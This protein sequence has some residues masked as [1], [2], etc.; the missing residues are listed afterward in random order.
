MTFEKKA[1]RVVLITGLSTALTI[2]FS[3]ISVPILLRY[4]GEGKYSEWIILISA[5]T[6]VTSVESRF[7]NYVG[8]KINYLYHKDKNKTIRYLSSAIVGI[9]LII[10]LQL[11]VVILSFKI[12]YLGNI[13]GINHKFNGLNNQSIGLLILLISW[14]ITGSYIVILHRLL[15]PTGLMVEGAWWAIFL[16]FF[17]FLVIIV[18]AFMDLSIPLAATFYAIVQAIVYILTAIYIRYKI[19]KLFPDI[20]Y[21]DVKTGVNI[22]I[23]SVPYIISNIMQQF[24]NSGMILLLTVISGLS[25]VPQ[26]STVKLLSSIWGNVSNILVQPILPE[27]IRLHAN[28]EFR[29]ISLLN[30]TYQATACNIINWGIILSY[31]IMGYAYRI[32]TSNLLILNIQLLCCFLLSAVL[33]NSGSLMNCY[34]IGINNKKFNLI[35]S[36]TRSIISISLAIILFKFFRIT[37]IGLAITIS[38]LVILV[39]T[40]YYFYGVNVNIKYKL[41]LPYIISIGAISIFFISE[42]FGL[43]E[44]KLLYGFTITTMIWCT[45]SLWDKIESHIKFRIKLLLIEYIK[46]IFLVRK[47]NKK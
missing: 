23:K 1:T 2:V 45:K 19:P 24:S 43:V 39:I 9:G 29:K 26:Y 11:I 44:F 4:W 5:F 3:M 40:C 27:V 31:P 37:G 21:V 42:C 47:F 36:F 32:W 13:F 30:D 18:S 46:K 41:N 14:G 22:L 35:I 16:R 38:E 6:I 7:V 15:P 25:V 17:Q 8:N 10:I 28:Y 33:L 34:L 12:E 20:K